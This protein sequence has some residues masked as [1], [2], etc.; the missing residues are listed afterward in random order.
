MVDPAK[1]EFLHKY[2]QTIDAVMYD[3]HT[4]VEIK[5]RNKEY[6]HYPPPKTSVHT[7]SVMQEAQKLGFDIQLATVWIGR[8]GNFEIEMSRFES[9]KIWVDSIKRYDKGL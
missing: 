4:L 5:T 3:G 8:D 6:A 1:K 7:V 2:W 9:A